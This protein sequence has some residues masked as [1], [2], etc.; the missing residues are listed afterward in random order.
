MMMMN[1]DGDIESTS[2]HDVQAISRWDWM[3][4]SIF[5]KYLSHVYHRRYE[6]QEGCGCRGCRFGYSLVE[7]DQGGGHEFEYQVRVRIRSYR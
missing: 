4:V 5:K 7:L 6:S 3:G 2:S 1:L